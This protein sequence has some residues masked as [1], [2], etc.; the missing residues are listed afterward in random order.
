MI[1]VPKLEQPKNEIAICLVKPV[2]FEGD[3]LSEIEA[4]RK[5]YSRMPSPSKSFDFTRYKEEA[6]CVELD[7]LF[8]GKCAYCESVY[9]AVDSKDI[10]HFRPKGG[11]TGISPKLH[12]GYWWLAAEWSN[13]LVSCPPCNQHRRQ[14]VYKFGMTEEEIR[15]ARQK[16]PVERRGKG[17]H[18]PLRDEAKRAIKETDLLNL[19]DPLLIN[20]ALKNP[21]N[22][23][24]WIF[25]WN[26]SE[27]IWESDSLIAHVVAKTVYGAPD[28]YGAASIAIYGLDRLE[29]FRARVV[30]LRLAQDAVSSLLETL[31]DMSECNSG[32]KMQVLRTRLRKKKARLRQFFSRKQAYTGMT[33][34]FIRLA[35]SELQRLATG[36][37]AAP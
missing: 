4:A 3:K 35:F 31:Q 15:V 30:Q 24:E 26:K 14:T 22:H 16:S 27:A 10:E 20:P 5:F 2:N 28:P 6:V 21:N 29:L 32:A 11:V 19:E 33:R 37:S 12:Q 17:C 8:H 9:S 34:A 18:F 25:D 1:Y 13:L 7:R 36:A 23:L